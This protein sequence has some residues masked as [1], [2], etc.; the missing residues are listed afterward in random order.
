MEW[1][2]N[3]FGEG[4]WATDGFLLRGLKYPKGSGSDWAPEGLAE[5]AAY[6]K[7]H[8]STH[9]LLSGCNVPGTI[10]LGYVFNKKDSL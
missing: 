1:S 6:L 5:L 8:V 7:P 10:Q 2:W 9:Y 3:I 4:E